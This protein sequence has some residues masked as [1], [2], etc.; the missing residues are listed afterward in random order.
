MSDKKL[1]LNGKVVSAPLANIA[2][3]AYRA[4]A[5]RYGAAI[6]YSEMISVDGLVRGNRRTLDMLRLREGEKPV[7]FQIFGHD[8]KM[9]YDAARIVA[10]TGCDMIDI[11]FGCPA[12]KVVR[13]LSGAALMND[14]ELAE[15]LITAVVTAVDIPVSVKFRSGWNRESMSFIE[16]G[17][18]A[19][20]CGAS[21]LV[22]HPRTRASGFKGKSDWSK[23]KLL[24]ES[25][26]IDVIGSGDISTPE[27]AGRM[28]DET[29]CDYVMIGR[30][31]MGAPWIFQRIDHYLRTGD[32][33]GEP[34]LDQK[35]E[36]MLEFCRLMIDDFGERAAC[37]K[38]RKHLAWFTRGWHNVTRIRPLM[39][40]VENYRDIE[41]ILYNY[42][43]D[44]EKVA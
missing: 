30:A 16:F 17:K 23:L 41:K 19:E 40:S 22:L 44:L 9:I 7:C 10:G 24:K 38:L 6:A 5:L 2:G 25:V 13:N 42:L 28:I 15:K 26:G 34:P 21:Y 37:L 4:M 14:L 27:E 29:G 12:K 20:A 32:D 39:F 35:I 8:P 11:N 1:S 31:A 18:M 33:P 3:S 36:I 43:N